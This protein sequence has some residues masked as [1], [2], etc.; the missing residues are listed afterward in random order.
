MV[1]GR[2]EAQT[3]TERKKNGN[4]NDNVHSSCVFVILW[5]AK[6]FGRDSLACSQARYK[7]FLEHVIQE[8][9]EEFGDDIEVPWCKS[10]VSA[11]Q[12]MSWL[13]SDLSSLLVPRSWWIDTQRWSPPARTGME[14]LW[15]CKTSTESSCVTWKIGARKWEYHGIEVDDSKRSGHVPAGAYTGKWRAGSEAR[16]TSRR[17]HTYSHK[18]VAWQ[19]SDSAKILKPTFLD[20]GVAFEH[21]PHRGRTSTWLSVVSCTSVRLGS[22]VP[23]SVERFEMIPSKFERCWKILKDV[24]RCWGRCQE[25]WKVQVELEQHLAESQDQTWR[26]TLKGSCLGG[27]VRNLPGIR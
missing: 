14:C 26:E 24:E 16:W 11:Y 3:Q 9:R 2:N 5:L 21:S 18:V 17:I 4:G 20:F 6:G 19:N 25:F 10:C 1:F 27:F 15:W 7:D 8:S 22:C 13:R 12:N 23:L